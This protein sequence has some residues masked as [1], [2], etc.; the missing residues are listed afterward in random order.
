[1]VLS[2]QPVM[3]R[4]TVRLLEFGCHSRSHVVGVFK[5]TRSEYQIQSISLS[6]FSKVVWL[7]AVFWFT[8]HCN[9]GNLY[10][11]YIFLEEFFFLS[12]FLSVS[13]DTS[14]F[15]LLLVL[16]SI[17]KTVLFASVGMMIFWSMDFQIGDSLYSTTGGW[18]KWAMLSWHYFCSLFSQWVIMLWFG[19][20]TWKTTGKYW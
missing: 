1:M 17:W 4:W 16:N 3:E 10:K 19:Q 20:S 11:C 13:I 6:A 5:N 18:E 12:S 8:G 9:A 15:F 7:N 2:L 14:K